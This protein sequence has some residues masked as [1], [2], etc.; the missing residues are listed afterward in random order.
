[1][2]SVTQG[3]FLASTDF[4]AKQTVLACLDLKARANNFFIKSN[5]DQINAVADKTDAKRGA[6]ADQVGLPPRKHQQSEKLCFPR[7]H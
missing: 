1:M 4:Y 2:H 5:S 6:V 7:K 3:T